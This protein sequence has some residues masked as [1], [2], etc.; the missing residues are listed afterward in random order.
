MSAIESPVIEETE[1]T[2]LTMRSAVDATEAKV[3]LS[4]VGLVRAER[5]DM[6]NSAAGFVLAGSEARIERGGARTIIATGPIEISRGGAGAVLSLGDVRIS[7]GGGGMILARSA[8]VREGGFIAFAVTP[9]LN[10]AEGGRVLAGPREAA[11]IALV[12]AVAAVL[13]VVVTRLIGL[14]KG[15]T[16]S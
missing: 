1:S 6:A 14:R 9:R 12:G 8:E 13:T 16:T 4:A 7:Q 5:V 10:V 2:E 11:L 15:T 3:R